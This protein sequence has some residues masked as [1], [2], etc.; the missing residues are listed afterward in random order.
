M[1]SVLKLLILIFKADFVPKLVYEAKSPKANKLVASMA[2]SVSAGDNSCV[3]SANSFP[4]NEKV[5]KRAQ[6]MVFSRFFKFMIGK[7]FNWFCIEYQY[8]RYLITITRRFR[9]Q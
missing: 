9:L 5:R 8:V 1:E 7:N 6:K 4:L 2:E 3:P